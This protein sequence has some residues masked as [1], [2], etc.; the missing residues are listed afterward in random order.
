[1]DRSRESETKY[2]I[3]PSKSKKITL[4]PLTSFRTYVKTDHNNVFFGKS[5]RPEPK[6]I[7]AAKNA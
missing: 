2:I 7:Y 5:Y 4:S 6:V 1:M 3:Y